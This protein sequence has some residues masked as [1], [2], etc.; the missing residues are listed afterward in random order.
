MPMRPEL[1]PPDWRA[2]ALAVKESNLWTCAACGVVCRKPGDAPGGNAPILTVAH[3]DHD[4]F[5]AEI[6]VAALCASCHLAHDREDNRLNRK[7]PVRRIY[8]HR[9]QR[10]AGQ[11]PFEFTGQQRQISN[12]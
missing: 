1:Y 6:Y 2:I 4:Y 9:K 5:S 8:R 10:S 12:G 3:I 7:P 11:L